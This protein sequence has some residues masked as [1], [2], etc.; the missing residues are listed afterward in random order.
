MTIEAYRKGR[1]TQVQS[2]AE[3]VSYKK[4]WTLAV[5]EERGRVCFEWMWRAPDAVTGKL[6]M[7]IRSGPEEVTDYATEDS[8]VKLVF[9]AVQWC[10]DHETREFFRYSGVQIFDP[11]KSVLPQPKQEA[12]DF[13]RRDLQR[14]TTFHEQ[15]EWFRKTLADS[16]S[17]QG[18]KE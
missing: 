10:E 9:R 1:L 7:Q 2:W 16:I 13:Y 14:L 5:Y 18:T 3:K 8:F 4:G 12:E 11:H 15:V 17:K 6:D